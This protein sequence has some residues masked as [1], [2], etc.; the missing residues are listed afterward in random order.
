MYQARWVK[1]VESIDV[2]ELVLW[3]SAQQRT[4]EDEEMFLRTTG[5]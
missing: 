2:A 4:M 5:F 1:F 3:G